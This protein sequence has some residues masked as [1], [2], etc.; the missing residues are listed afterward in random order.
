MSTCVCAYEYVAYVRYFG[1]KYVNVCMCV[2][3]CVCVCAGLL[4]W[5]WSMYESF[6][7]LTWLLVPFFSFSLS[8]S[9]SLISL[10]F[11]VISL[12]LFPLTIP[13]RRE[14]WDRGHK[15]GSSSQ[16]TSS[17]DG[18]RKD[19]GKAK[20]KGSSGDSAGEPWKRNTHR[21]KKGSWKMRRGEKEREGKWG[22]RV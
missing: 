13:L 19:A 3:V 17:T 18:R 10:A 7:S 16:L 1:C 22:E 21:E 15:K 11:F 5:F 12:T 20:R 14:R 6:R 9:L 4:F 2:C 8:L